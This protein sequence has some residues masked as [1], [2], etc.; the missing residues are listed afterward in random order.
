MKKEIFSSRYNKAPTEVEAL[1]FNL[2]PEDGLEPSLPKETDFESVVYTNFTTRAYLL[3]HCLGKCSHYTYATF[4][5][6]S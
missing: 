3:R 1:L 4:L 6:N 5:R 2:V